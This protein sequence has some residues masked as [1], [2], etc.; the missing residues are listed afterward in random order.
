MDG[1][2]Q[3][4]FRCYCYDIPQDT[5]LSDWHLPHRYWRIGSYRV[6]QGI[7][8]TLLVLRK[9]GKTNGC[10]GKINPISRPG[11]NKVVVLASANFRLGDGGWWHRLGSCFIESS[12]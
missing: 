11:E 3:S 8:V 9:G 10:S 4:H 7:K 6:F 12:D 5:Q 2:S 1:D